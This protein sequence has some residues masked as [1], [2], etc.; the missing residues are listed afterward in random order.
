ML[1]AGADAG[2][3]VESQLRLAEAMRAAGA[4]VEAVVYDGAPHS[5]FDRSFAEWSGACEDAWGRVLELIERA[6]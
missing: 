2:T 3:P 5:F 6:S 4:E 1:I